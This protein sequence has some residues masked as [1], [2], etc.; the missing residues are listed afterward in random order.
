[1][2]IIYSDGYHLQLGDHV[3]PSVKYKMTKDRLVEEAICNPSDMIQPEPA[4]EDDVRLVH[5]GEVRS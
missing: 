4:W 2:K 1:M 5:T 3:F